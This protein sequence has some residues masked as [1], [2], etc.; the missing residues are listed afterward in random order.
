MSFRDRFTA[1]SKTMA[2]MVGKATTDEVFQ[3]RI[4]ICNECPHLNSVRQCRECGCFVDGKARLAL[5]ECPIKK[6]SHGPLKS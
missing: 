3:S 4:D 6:W 5:Q 1:A 2:E